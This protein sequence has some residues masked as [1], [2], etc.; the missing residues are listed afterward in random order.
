M[1]NRIIDWLLKHKILKR[2]DWIQIKNRDVIDVT[3]EGPVLKR[4]VVRKQW[5]A[6][7]SGP[8]PEYNPHTGEVKTWPAIQIVEDMLIEYAL[9]CQ[10]GVNMTRD[11]ARIAADVFFQLE[12]VY[13]PLKWW[14]QK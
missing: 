5:A 2:A 3:L 6:T 12:L 8:I 14:W 11:Q 13:P 4:L 7:V 9:S 1:K 10:P